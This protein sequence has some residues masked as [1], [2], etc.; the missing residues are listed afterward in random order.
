MRDKGW[1]KYEFL[2]NRLSF[3]AKLRN[4]KNGDFS[5]RLK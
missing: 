5:L 4:L 3:K 2:Q 1:E